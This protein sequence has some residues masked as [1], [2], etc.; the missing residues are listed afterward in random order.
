MCDSSVV[1]SLA[2]MA[3]YDLVDPPPLHTNSLLQLR[4][5]IQSAYGWLFVVAFDLH[6]PS[7]FLLISPTL[8]NSRSKSIYKPFVSH[9][10]VSTAVWGR[11]LVHTCCGEGS[12]TGMAV[13]CSG[14][15]QFQTPL[16]LQRRYNISVLGSPWHSSIPLR[17]YA[18]RAQEDWGL[19]LSHSLVLLPR[20]LYLMEEKQV[21]E[22]S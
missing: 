21:F 9:P 2:L 4:D 6:L 8:I 12:R 17:I 10:T 14:T 5:Q 20:V 3:E 11:C 1:F 18:C 7:A 22:Y 13:V 19:P 16:C 15:T